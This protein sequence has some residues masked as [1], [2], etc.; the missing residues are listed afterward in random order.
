MISIYT[1]YKE[2]STIAALLQAHEQYWAH[3]PV[4]G[5]EATKQPE[6]LVEHCDL[7]ND[8]FEKLCEV[9]GLEPVID[10]LILG[11]TESFFK[12]ESK[13]NDWIKRLFVNTIAF[14][15]FGKVNE[16]FQSSRMRN[17][18]FK[19]NPKSPFTPAHGHSWLGAYMYVG[20]FISQIEQDDELED[21]ELKFL[22]VLI[23]QFSYT[24]VKHHSPFLDEVKAGVEK[25][26]FG[27]FYSKVQRYL[28]L[29]NFSF[30]QGL[31]EFVFTDIESFWSEFERIAGQ[32]FALF[33]LLKLNFS[34]LTASDY[35]ATHEYMSGDETKDFGVLR[36]RIR[37]KELINNLRQFEHNSDTFAQI[38][39]GYVFQ[40]ATLRQKSKAN[41]NKLRREMAIELIQTIRQFPDKRLYYIEAPTG[42]GK[43]N[44]SMIALTELLENNSE[45][46]KIFYVFP[47]TTLITQTYKALQRTLQLT[48]L[49]LV[50]LHSK[51]GFQSKSEE[52]KEDGVY[53]RDKKDYIDNLFALYPVTLLSHVRFFDILKTNSKETNYLLHRLANSVVIVDE[54]QSYNPKIWDKM[55]YFISQYAE[56]FNIRF[57]LM[58]ATLPKLDKLDLK[59]KPL[60]IF[61]EL[62]PNAQTYLQ[63]PNFA[64]RVCFNFDLYNRQFDAK[65]ADD[66]N[67]LARTVIDKSE[68]FAEQNELHG[69]VHTI[70]EFIYK[71]SA[72]TFKQVIENSDH[73]FD[74]L[75]VLSGTILEFRRRQIINQLKNPSYRKKNILLITTQ[76]VEAGVDIDMD[77]GFKNISLLDS[78]E[79]LA[80]RVN[81][82]ASKGL[83]EV[84]LFR[85][86]DASVLYNGDYRYK[87]IK[88]GEV[89]QEE[90]REILTDK[91]FDKL[92]QQVF[93]R[94]DKFNS[95]ILFA[96][97]FSGEILENLQRLDF[98]K[99][100]KN[101]KIINQQNESVYVPLSIPIELDRPEEDRSFSKDDLRFLEHY[102]VYH[103]G[104]IHICG[105]AVWK[106]YERLIWQDVGN[107]KSGKGF[108]L[109][110]KINF[111]ALQSILAKYTFSLMANSN[112]IQQVKAG[113]GE[114]KYG[115][116]YFSH[117]DEKRMNGQPYDEKGGLDAE[118]FSDI[119][120]I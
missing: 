111:K 40:E 99:I 90:A 104:D 42:G 13:I 109:D 93:K 116:V 75:F 23:W 25:A 19:P 96:D 47:F 28:Q 89:S 6:K 114:E 78:D 110:L 34:L 86:D 105:K 58:S 94:I 95:N 113:L 76:V 88:N 100:D 12:K 101:F 53:G 103:K 36:D 91:R 48:N 44:L 63:N 56:Y 8:Y 11:L 87:A 70:I 102:E 17:P 62:L 21:T 80:G 57:I 55:L 73:S 79:Q 59:L 46:R 39:A 43:T 98:S 37:I 2:R 27:N 65:N 74:E 45:L 64:E 9:H 15:D 107:R 7:V 5:E 112:D 97:N 24:I 77:L 115:F 68:K 16:D 18:L 119:N 31:S 52:K 26:D 33:A 22:T 72:S 1:L 85:L 49:E 71:K 81:R 10:R 60:P 14:H 35:L 84:Y 83:C 118:A 29:Y 50:E 3:L 30:A 66:W 106:L 82:N 92:Y 20:Y 61:Q 38:D 120:F 108:D 69:S 4:K 51:A 32:S 54:L 41:L 67:D 117:W